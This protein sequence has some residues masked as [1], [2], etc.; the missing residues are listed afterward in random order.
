[1]SLEAVLNVDP[2]TRALGIPGHLRTTEDMIPIVAFIRNMKIFSVMDHKAVVKICRKIELST[3]NAGSYVFQEGQVGTAF[4]IVLDG[5]IAIQRKK[6]HYVENEIKTEIVTLVNLQWGQYFGEAALESSDGLRTATA[7]A[8]IKTR[9]LSLSVSDY[10]DVL[11]EFKSTMKNEVMAVLLGSY[12]IFKNWDLSKLDHMAKFAS[13]RHYSSNE[14]MMT[15]GV[16]VNSLMIIKTGIVRIIKDIPAAELSLRDRDM[17]AINKLAVSHRPS[18]K[19]PLVDARQSTEGRHNSDS[20]HLQFPQLSE[21]PPASS[22]HHYVAQP[23][24]ARLLLKHTGPTLS[25]SRP[26]T[27]DR[28]SNPLHESSTEQTSLLGGY[29]LNKRGTIEGC[30]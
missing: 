12:S 17:T 24:P 4:Y 23:P 14:E 7:I 21:R 26:V 18:F 5:N 13:L 30:V 11:F 10:H 25:A 16:N 8:T 27:T 15:K 6:R 1:M 3:F 20:S 28:K 22:G 2:M 9:L 29:L 19:S